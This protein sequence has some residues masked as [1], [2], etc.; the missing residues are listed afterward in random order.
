[1]D[2]WVFIFWM[3][4]PD[5]DGSGRMEERMLTR[6]QITQQACARERH[7]FLREELF[8]PTR[9]GQ[10]IAYTDCVKKIYAPEKKS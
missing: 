4:I 7:D 1:M 6:E 10:L 5:A 8:K 3:M 2:A 9:S